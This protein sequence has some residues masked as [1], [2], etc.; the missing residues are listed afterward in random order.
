MRAYLEVLEGEWQ[1]DGIEAQLLQAPHN[2]CKV[3]GKA[4]VAPAQ[5]PWR[6]QASVEAIPASLIAHLAALSCVLATL[7]WSEGSVR[8]GDRGHLLKPSCSGATHCLPVLGQ[9]VIAPDQNPQG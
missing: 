8:D 9:A 6:C 7:A 2:G 4:V 1:A 3:L 5:V